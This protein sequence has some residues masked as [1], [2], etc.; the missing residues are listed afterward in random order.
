MGLPKEHRIEHL[1]L[2]VE[3]LDR[4]IE[5]YTGVVGL[6]ELAREDGVA[7]LGCGLDDNWDVAFRQGPTRVEHV[8]FRVSDE[9]EFERTERALGEHN[10]A[11]ERRDGAEPNQERGLRFS[12]PSGLAVEYVAVTD[13]RYPVM[14]D[15]THPRLRGFSPL[16]LDHI[17]IQSTDV[18]ETSR[19]F[20]EVL[21][22]RETEHVEL[23]PSSGAWQASF[24]RK[25]SMHHDITIAQGPARMHH[26][27]LAMASF[28]HLKLAIDALASVGERIELGPSRHLAGGNIFTYYRLPDGH[29]LELSVEMSVI[30]DDTPARTWTDRGGFDAWGGL[31]PTPEFMIGS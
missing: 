11:A 8:A 29:R 5:F 1:E 10:V 19:F 14:A 7:Y 6:V 28:D 27:A 20:I 24:L 12:L 15:P 18:R 2:S 3:D 16:D 17:A 31:H 21:G 9:D 23:D 25:G 22:W 30:D 4:T 13:K 26:W